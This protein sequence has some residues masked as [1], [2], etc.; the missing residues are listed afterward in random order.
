MK[1]T[2]IQ[3]EPRHEKTRYCLCSNCTADQRLCFCYSLTRIVQ[4]LL[5]LNLKFQ[6]S[7][8]LLLPHRQVCVRPGRK[9]RR[10]VFLRHGSNNHIIYPLF[11]RMYMYVKMLLFYCVSLSQQVVQF[12]NGQFALIEQQ[13]NIDPQTVQHLVFEQ[14]PPQQVVQAVEEVTRTQTEAKPL[15]APVK[16][17]PI[18]PPV[19]KVC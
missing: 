1:I 10:P 18:Q 14:V 3:N 7:S 12:A 13:E 6:A 19:G 5:F 15:P 9:P 4:F 11:S 17:E 16:H 8:H 2:S